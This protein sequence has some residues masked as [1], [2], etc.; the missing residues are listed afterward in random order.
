MLT[1]L[2]GGERDPQVLAQLAR[3]SMY[4]K[5]SRLEEAFTGRFE[6]HQAFPLAKVLSRVDGID[7]DL[8][9]IDAKIGALIVPFR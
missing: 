3:G 1:A 5:I 7:A 8:A 4:G 2:V 9:D 6:D